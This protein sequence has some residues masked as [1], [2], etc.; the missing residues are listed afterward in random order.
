MKHIPRYKH[1]RQEIITYTTAA[2]SKL[3]RNL[4]LRAFFCDKP[5]SDHTPLYPRIPSTWTPDSSTPGVTDID[6]WYTAMLAK[7]NNYKMPLTN[8]I[9]I[10]DTNLLKELDALKSLPVV[11]KP[12]DKNLGTALLSPSQYH[13]L[14]MEHLNDSTTYRKLA[15]TTN[16]RSIANC[17]FAKLRCILDKH[18]HLYEMILDND[19]IP[20]YKKQRND[21]RTFTRLARSLLQ[22][23]PSIQPLYSEQSSYNTTVQHSNTT[24]QPATAT[25]LRLASFYILPK[26]HKKTISGRPIANTINT[27][28]YMTSCYLHR[29]LL[30]PLPYLRTVVSSTHAALQRLLQLHLPP[31]AVLLCADV[32][33]LY[34]SIPIDYG[35]H[36]VESVLSQ[37]KQRRLISTNIPLTI[38]LLRW[39]LTNNYI[40]YLDEVYLQLTGTAMGTPVAVMYANIVLAHLE[41]SA[42]AYNP[43]LYMRYIDDLCILCTDSEQA[44]NIVHTFNQ[45]CPS[46]KLDEVTI[47]TSGVFLDLNIELSY[48]PYST[49]INISTY[50][51][52]I[53]KYMYITP[54]SHHQRAILKNFIFN[55][56]CRYRLHCISDSEFRKLVRLFNQRIIRRGYNPNYII[57]IYNKLPKRSE[58]LQ[59]LFNPKSLNKI[60][61]IVCTL[62]MDIASFIPA[63]KKFLFPSSSMILNPILNPICKHIIFNKSNDPNLIKHLCNEAR[64]KS[65]VKNSLPPQPGHI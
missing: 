1:S 58:L 18:G 2:L 64:T 38:D 47:S 22:L 31:N 53:N 40:T 9:S 20:V 37:L 24:A 17:T 62:P 23:Q 8:K 21:Q 46:I 15:N 32:K 29:V 4:K 14:C 44:S 30:E 36:A 13:N 54:T 28:T 26:L 59:R 48:Q 33:S 65:I 12:A 55:E 63:P 41:Q 52:S 7:I 60:Q 35:L 57:H 34:P 25:A 11:I 50:Q 6:R 49:E 27:C 51:K 45:Q 19:G 3:A 56:L 16:L 43:Y 61:P 42:A 5:S 10:Y 39:T